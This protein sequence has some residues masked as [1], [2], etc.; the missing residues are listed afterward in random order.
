MK[1]KEIFKKI[2]TDLDSNGKLVSPRGLLI[3]ELENY[4]YEL[5]PFIRFSSFKSRKFNLSYLK[6]EFL[7]YLKGDR[8]DSSIEEHAS[9][10][11]TIKNSDGSL[12]SNYGQYIF[13]EQNQFDEVVNILTVDKDSRRA[14]ILILNTE[15]IISNTKDVPCTY[16]INFRIRN[17]ELNMTVHMRSQ[18]IV[19]G[20]GN[21]C[22][23]FSFIHEMLLHVLREIYPILA[24]GTYTHIVDSFHVYEKHFEMI[25]NIANGDEYITIDCPKISD[26]DEVNF[27]RKLHK[28]IVEIPENYKFTKWLLN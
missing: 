20:M 16:A 6:K 1:S 22:P 13:G 24:Y 8:F 25:K 4:K 5:P 21:D 28:G 12:N 2:F 11:K 3:K 27:L 26:S 18:D 14:S 10:W 15:H 9:L 19:F 17:N 7:W 23:T